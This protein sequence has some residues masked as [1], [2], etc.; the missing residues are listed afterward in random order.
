MVKSSPETGDKVE[1]AMPI[2]S[3]V[4]VGNVDI[5]AGPW[6]R[7]LIAELAAFPSGATKDQVDA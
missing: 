1:R 5:V 7:A 4:N 3:Q 2:A 6:T